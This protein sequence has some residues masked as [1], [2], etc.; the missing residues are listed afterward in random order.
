MCA[1]L[2]NFKQIF[3]DYF[4]PYMA[5]K[6][7][8]LFGHYPA[9]REQADDCDVILMWMKLFLQIGRYSFTLSI[10]LNNRPNVR[11]FEVQDN[12]ETSLF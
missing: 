5:K 11:L 3:V 4:L 7:Q 2:F 9:K 10:S 12:L 8:L 6:Y 1:F